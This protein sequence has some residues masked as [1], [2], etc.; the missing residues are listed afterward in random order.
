MKIK[1][2]NIPVEKTYVRKVDQ[3]DTARTMG[4]I[5]INN[6]KEKES[7]NLAPQ[8]LSDNGNTLLN[9]NNRLIKL[10]NTDQ[11]LALLDNNID[12]YNVE[13]DY[14]DDCESNHK[15]IFAPIKCI[16]LKK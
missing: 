6:N 11:K 15:F 2:R 10:K 12:D 8:L 3:M 16:K 13:N 14:D 1:Q 7:S 4:N 5:Q 9:W